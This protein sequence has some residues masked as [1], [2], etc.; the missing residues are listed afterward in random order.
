MGA[1]VMVCCWRAPHTPQTRARLL[2]QTLLPLLDLD[3]RTSM[4]DPSSPL[5]HMVLDIAVV[6]VP[7]DLA[8]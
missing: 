7:A 1:D 2:R 8:M 4:Q 5:L 3:S 6:N